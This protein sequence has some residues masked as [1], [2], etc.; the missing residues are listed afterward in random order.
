[1]QKLEFCLPDYFR[2]C[3]NTCFYYCLYDDCEF[4]LCEVNLEFYACSFE[5][6]D[7]AHSDGLV[8][9][10]GLTLV[11]KSNKT[12]RRC[13]ENLDFLRL[14]YGVVNYVLVDLTW[15]KN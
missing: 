13:I 1:M 3:G 8:L 14:L 10:D 9:L 5:D 15:Q 12:Y 4:E 2:L 6:L 11:G 7:N